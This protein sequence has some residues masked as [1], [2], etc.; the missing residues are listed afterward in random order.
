MGFPLPGASAGPLNYVIC[1]HVEIDG[2]SRSEVRTEF[3]FS[4]ES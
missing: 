1:P 3:N 2:T 4:D